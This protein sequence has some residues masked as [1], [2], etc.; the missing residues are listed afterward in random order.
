MKPLDIRIKLLKKG[1]SL[2]DVARKCGVDR[3]MVRYALRAPGRY[4]ET[5][6]LKIREA[7]AQEIK[8]PIEKIWRQNRKAA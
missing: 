6:V 5:K 3:Q 8:I 7:V 1:L 4:R 2:A